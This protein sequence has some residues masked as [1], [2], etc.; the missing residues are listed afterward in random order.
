MKYIITDFVKNVNRMIRRENYAGKKTAGE[1]AVTVLNLAWQV[2]IQE[3]AGKGL[4]AARLVNNNTAAAILLQILFKNNYFVPAESLCLATAKEVLT[5]MNLLRCNKHTE[6]VTGIARDLSDLT[7]EYEA[8]MKG[9]DLYDGA[10]VLA[11]A[12]ELLEKDPG[13]YRSEWKDADFEKC[14]FSTPST[15]E[16]E[17]VALIAGA[18]SFDAVNDYGKPA[19]A[20]NIT[21]EFIKCYG[22]VNEADFVAK[23]I[24]E[25]KTPLGDVTVICDPKTYGPYLEEA[26][27]KRGL[28]FTYTAGVPASGLN[29]IQ[30]YKDL[31]KWYQS[32][33]RYEELFQVAFNPIFAMKIKDAATGAEETV[34]VGK[35]FLKGISYN[36]GWGTDRYMHVD[37]TAYD[38]KND[39]SGLKETPD[40]KAF[41]TEML[42]ELGELGDQLD[43]ASQASDFFDAL[44]DFVNSHKPAKNVEYKVITAA[45][46]NLRKNMSAAGISFSDKEDVADYVLHELDSLSYSETEAPDAAEVTSLYA[47]VCPERKHLYVLGL[48]NKEF[49]VSTAESP[50]LGD[51]DR[52]ALFGDPACGNVTLAKDAVERKERIYKDTLEMA[53]EGS[54]IRLLCSTADIL[55]K[56]ECVAPSAFFEKLAE[57]RNKAAKTEDSYYE[58]T[59]HDVDIKREDYWKDF[60]TTYPPVTDPIEITFSK[61]RLD[62]F[63][64]CPLK[65]H[66]QNDLHIDEEEYREFDPGSWLGA[67]EKGT[68]IHRILELYAEKELVGNPSVSSVLDPTAKA[69]TDA[70]DKALKEAEETVPAP[71][72]VIRDA[73]AAECKAIAEEYLKELHSELHNE[74][75]VVVSCEEE[76]ITDVLKLEFTENGHEY[77]IK[78]SG[79]IDRIDKKTC[80]DGSV[81]YRI[82]DYKTGKYNTAEEMDK[83]TKQH[84]IYAQYVSKKYGE[85][86]KAEVEDFSYLFL[87]ALKEGRPE[88]KAEFLNG[89]LKREILNAG[90]KALIDAVYAEHNYLKK[91][92]KE[93]VKTDSCSKYCR[94]KD[95]C[96]YELV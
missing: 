28:N 17:V 11:E 30:L 89:E 90:E 24:I 57:T 41:R 58:I 49:G 51:N 85:K 16:Q 54:V 45:L 35:A 94:Y 21:Y 22:I 56:G 84:L 47:P 93:I 88:W 63:L 25:N 52:A 9:K 40:D 53:G 64:E 14:Y 1:E 72:A 82:A 78:F 42:K 4:M 34:P 60:D 5:N 65:S 13:K 8:V 33:C 27:A 36:V 76:M 87:S 39:P 43:K 31:I 62:T 26:F 61:S 71:N 46:L 77:V 66:Y 75:W 55:N 81:I 2:I 79:N 37:R 48:S 10:M 86:E 44:S 70:Y 29:V 73:E 7:R 95:I 20:G 3:K 92:R 18:G 12:K 96:M 50:V 38:R 74:G 23:D 69:F 19:K 67:N 83:K 68:M 32:G 15:L 59:N 6:P 91:T 80:E